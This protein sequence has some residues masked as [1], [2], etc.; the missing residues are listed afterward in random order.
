MRVH[1]VRFTV[2]VL[3]ALFAPALRAKA[4]ERGPSKWE[5]PALRKLFPTSRSLPKAYRVRPEDNAARYLIGGQVLTVSPE[6]QRPVF[7]PIGVRKAGGKFEPLLLGYEPTLGPKDAKAAVRAA[8]QAWRGGRGAWPRASMEERITAVERFATYLEVNTD[9]IATLLMLEIGKPYEAARTEVKRTV[10]YVRRTLVE[11]RALEEEGRRVYS[12]GQGG[13][14]RFGRTALKPVGTVLAVAPFNYPINEGLTAIIPALLMGNVVIAKTP[15]FGVLANQALLEGFAAAFPKGV[16]SVLPGDGRVLLPEIMKAKTRQGRPAIDVLSF[17]GGERGARAVVKSH[18]EP[19]LWLQKIL[20]LGAK[21]AGVVLRG[22]KPAA[23]VD[24]LL[25]GALGFNG[26]RC[27]AE[28]I[29]FVPRSLAAELKPLL[30]ERMAAYEPA[31]PWRK[32][33]KITPLVEPGKAGAM[34]AYVDDALGKGAELLSGGSSYQ[35]V[36]RPALLWGVTDQMTI[37]KEEQFGPVVPVVIY[38]DLREVYRWHRN[39]PFGQQVSVFGPEKDVAR[40][41]ERLEVSVARV[42]QNHTSQ[43]SP[44]SFPFTGTRFSGLGTLSLRDALVSFSRPVVK[45]ARTA[46]ELSGGGG[47]D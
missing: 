6:K 44:D 37:A 10:E 47:P 9:R 19:E 16:V 32:G 21:N 36:M 23:I 45:S 14:Q 3:V 13:G 7:S 46:G 11:A 1:L 15:R 12:D 42:N 4:P 41:A 5:D 17:I 18:P 28:K 31:M 35:S 29:L 34:Q 39:T 2:L 20:G 40:V 25:E 33:A 38:D 24:Q 43:R 30:K 27:T 8:Q 22:A 26:Q